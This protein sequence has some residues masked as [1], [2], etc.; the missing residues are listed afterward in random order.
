MVRDRFADYLCV[1]GNTL[2]NNT[3]QQ[4][5]VVDICCGVLTCSCLL[6]CANPL[7]QLCQGA[8]SLEAQ[9]GSRT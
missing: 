1:L 8:S 3:S 9:A 5:P 2:G 4:K 6:L 7:L